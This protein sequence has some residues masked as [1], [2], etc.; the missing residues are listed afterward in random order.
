MITCT[1]AC[2]TFEH[3]RLKVSQHGF[4]LSL[5]ASKQALRVR[6]L[7]VIFAF[8]RG[9]GYHTSINRNSM[10]LLNIAQIWNAFGTI[11]S[12]NSPHPGLQVLAMAALLFAVHS[13]HS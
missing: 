13:M 7:E 11:V 6:Q 9:F 10:I 1:C 5:G 3:F 2:T 4:V 8:S 12:R